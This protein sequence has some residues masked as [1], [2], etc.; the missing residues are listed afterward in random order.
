[1]V[2]LTHTEDSRVRRFW[3]TV[4]IVEG[5]WVWQ[6]SKTDGY[7]HMSVSAY[8]TGYAHKWLWE[9]LNGPVPSGLELDHVEIEPALIRAI[10]KL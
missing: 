6:G 9:R 10:W 1:M 3:N 4:K 8:K 7:G 2:F 5:C